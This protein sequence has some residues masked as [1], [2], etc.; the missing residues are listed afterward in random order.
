MKLF[1]LFFFFVFFF[2]IILWVSFS[3][4]YSISFSDKLSLFSIFSIFFISVNI[5]FIFVFFPILEDVAFIFNVAM[6]S[7]MVR[8]FCSGF[9]STVHQFPYLSLFSIF[10]SQVQNEINKKYGL[11]GLMISIN[12]RLMKG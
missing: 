12:M 3:A 6:I 10:L 1:F 9:F 4:F 8:Q 5:S 2:F 7:G 11:C